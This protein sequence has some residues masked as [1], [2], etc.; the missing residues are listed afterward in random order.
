IDFTKRV[1]ELYMA[2]R[3]GSKKNESSTCVN[4]EIK[5]FIES[6]YEMNAADL[7]PP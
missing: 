6:G 2:S 3:K 5:D 4:I 7:L 1:Q